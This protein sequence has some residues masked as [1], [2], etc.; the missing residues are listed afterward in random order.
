MTDR[1]VSSEASPA[2]SSTSN[3]ADP[4]IGDPGP[5]FDPD[6][7]AAAAAGVQ[8]DADQAAR[9][10]TADAFSIP[11]VEEESVRSVLFNGGDM[12]HAL[13]GVGEQDWRATQADLDR[14]APP[15]TR[16]INRYDISRAVAQKSDEA[17]VIIG[18]GMWSWR[19]ML[20]R[21]AVLHAREQGLDPADFVPSDEAPKPEPRPPAPG[22]SP[23]PVGASFEVAPGYVTTAERLRQARERDP[24]V[25]QP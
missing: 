6:A 5:G 9:E 20:E 21:R 4:F 11:D 16:I 10:Q 15:A 19:S 1:P 23:V 24:R 7:G 14:I 17:A 3:G 12:L 22:P 8:A 18:M 2:A 13:A 25:Q